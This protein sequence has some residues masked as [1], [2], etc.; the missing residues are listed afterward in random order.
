[1]DVPKPAVWL[2]W[3]DVVHYRVRTDSGIDAGATEEC[4]V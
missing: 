4:P 3:L 2:V 1:M